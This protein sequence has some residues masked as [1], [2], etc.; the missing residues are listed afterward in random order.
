MADEVCVEFD[1]TSQSLDALRAAAY[2]LVNLA[3]CQIDKVNNRFV[4]TLTLRKDNS[5]SKNSN[6]EFIRLRFI[7]LVTD[8]NLRERVAIKTEPVRNLILSLAFGSLASQDNNK[9]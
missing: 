1:C 8:E 5:A 7:D 6:V 9:K 4:C 2:R 3:S